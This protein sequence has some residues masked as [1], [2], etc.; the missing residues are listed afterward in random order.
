ML[1]APPADDTVA[2]SIAD[3]ARRLGI[4]RTAVYRLIRDGELQS[5]HIGRR[6]L[7]PLEALEALA[8]PR[9][10]A[11]DPVASLLHRTRTERGM[12]LVIDD[13]AII[14]KVA[15]IVNAGGATS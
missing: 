14:A 12:A 1:P 4:G 3:A 13:P 8:R 5:F 6:H 2:V 7:I 15:A 9:N 10:D 11:D